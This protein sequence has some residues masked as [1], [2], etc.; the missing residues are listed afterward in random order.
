MD[1][2]NK[3]VLTYIDSF[4]PYKDTLILRQVNKNN[5][6]ILSTSYTKKKYCKHHRK[7]VLRFIATSLIKRRILVKH[8]VLKLLHNKQFRKDNFNIHL[9]ALSRLCICFK[10][11]KSKF[12]NQIHPARV[13]N[14]L[15]KHHPHIYYQYISIRNVPEFKQWFYNFNP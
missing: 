10:K 14:Y 6:R 15:K 11:R 4:L 9:D 13:T 1:N 2:L 12:Y 3:D 5:N 8:F 7:I